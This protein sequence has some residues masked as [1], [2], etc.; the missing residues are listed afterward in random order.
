MSDHIQHFIGNGSV[1]RN[2]SLHKSSFGYP[3]VSRV[4]KLGRPFSTKSEKKRRGATQQMLSG[5][6]DSSATEAFVRERNANI[7]RTTAKYARKM[8][9]SLPYTPSGT[10]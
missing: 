9:G 1:A 4:K 3:R 10:G 7:R 8:K 2:E 5:A 6:Q